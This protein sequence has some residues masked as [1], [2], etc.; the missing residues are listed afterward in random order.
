MTF[1][2]LYLFSF[3]CS[4]LGA[5]VLLK[6]GYRLGVNDVPNHRSSHVKETPK[7]AGIGILAAS[8][9]SAIYLSVPVW[10]W[11]PATI[12]ALISFWGGDKQQLSPGKRLIIQFLC[13]LLILLFLGIVEGR[14]ALFVLLFFPLSVFIVGTANFYNFMDGIDGIAGMTAVVGFS[15]LAYYSH[16]TNGYMPYGMFSMTIVFA[17]LGFLVFNLPDAKV[18][19]G[20]VGSVLLG[21]LFACLVVI[22]SKNIIDFMIM[23]GFIWPFYFDEIFTMIVRMRNKDSLVE[24]HRK[25]IYQLLANELSVS[26]WK[27]SLSYGIIQLFVGISAIHIVQIW[28]LLS[29]II[30][31]IIY[32]IIFVIV[33]L[34]VH[35]KAVE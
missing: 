22:L 27:I 9:V 29:L 3:L 11:I 33:S 13:S 15:M 10:V 21:F 4:G 34:K 1:I 20:D 17:C 16:F 5:W 30:L 24:P 8:M 6:I 28:G 35:Q 19:L 31:Y 2:N 23:A 14:G 7:G 26:H 25:H 32:S 12:I 18:F